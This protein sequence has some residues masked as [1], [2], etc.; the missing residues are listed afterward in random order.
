M[1][2]KQILTFLNENKIEELKN[3]LLEEELFKARGSKADTKKRAM[4][5]K[6]YHANC[7]KNSKYNKYGDEDQGLNGMIRHLDKVGLCDAHTVYLSKE[8]QK[9]DFPSL[10]VTSNEGFKIESVME[11][12]GYND[13]EVNR[14][15]ILQALEYAKC[16]D[17]EVNAK[18][19]K[20]DKLII[21]IKIGDVYLNYKLF[22]MLFPTIDNNSDTYVVKTLKSTSPAYIDNDCGT[23]CVLPV[24]V[25][26]T[27]A[28]KY[29]QDFNNISVISE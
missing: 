12:E 2:N 21:F 8:F 17:K 14:E 10:Q 3:M 4:A 16:R 15:D 19:T 20:K 23:I 24:N 26:D 29:R 27:S 6:K 25:K 22:G 7:L 9:E 13:T 28:H 5:V 11:F 1:N 18:K